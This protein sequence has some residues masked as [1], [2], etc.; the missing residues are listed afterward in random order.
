MDCTCDVRVCYSFV[1]VLNCKKILTEFNEDVEFMNNTDDLSHYSFDR[2]HRRFIGYGKFKINLKQVQ[3][4][5][6]NPKQL[7]TTET[8]ESAENKKHIDRRSHPKQNFDHFET[9]NLFGNRHIFS[10]TSLHTLDFFT[11][12]FLVVFPSK[13]RVLPFLKQNNYFQFFI[14]I[15]SFYYSFVFILT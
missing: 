11:L 4:Q 9:I 8:D 5:R 6:Q 13:P 1:L 2:F 3:I 14:P 12:R 7:T 15:Y 10:E